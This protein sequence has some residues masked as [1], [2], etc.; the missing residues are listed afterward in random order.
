MDTESRKRRA[1]ESALGFVEI[2]MVVG[3]GTGSTA[4]HF[5]EALA[6]IRHRIDGAVASSEATAAR[7]RAHGMRVLDLNAVD[8]VSVY[9]DGADECTRHRQLVK[10]GGGA[11]TREKIVAAVA[12]RFV[13]IVDD[14]KLVD[15]LGAAFPVAVEVIPMARGHVARQL[16]ALGG[17]PF[18]REGFVTDNGNAILDVR[19]LGTPR[20]GRDRERDQ[21]DRGGRGERSLCPAPGR[22]SADR[23]ARIG[24]QAAMKRPS[25]R[26]RYHRGPTPDETPGGAVVKGRGALSNRSGRYESTTRDIADDG[27]GSLDDTLEALGR[28]ETS[29]EPDTSRTVI[30]RNQSPDIPF[31]RSIN[32]YRGCEHGCI[33]CYARP[34]HAWLGL[35]P[36]RDFETKL[37]YKA[38]AVELL[39]D[40]LRAP[41]YRCAPIALG[42]NTDPYQPVERR[43]RITRG[44][45]AL[46]R[47]CAH[48]ATIVTKSTL[49][50]RD[51]DLLV[52]MAERSL[53]GVSVSVT[54]LDPDLARRMEPRAAGPRQRLAAIER[55]RRLDVPVAVL[56]APII[57]GLN[58][59]E[60]E[61]ILRSVR[62]RGSARRGLR[63]AAAAAGGRRPVPRMARRPLPAQGEPGPGP[64]PR[65]PRRAGLSRRV[66]NP[67]ARHRTLRRPHRPSVPA[68]AAPARLPRNAGPRFEPIRA[69]S[70]GRR[71]AG[72]HGRAGTGPPARPAA[73]RARRVSVIANP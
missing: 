1:A 44:I 59:H 16:V 9:V 50:E 35:S 45:L 30:A 37:F 70:G 26:A 67:H 52:P 38:N 23:R 34:T 71:P 46:L 61:A 57:P 22:R 13:C 48:P 39:R 14:S 58:D 53:V 4:N 65:D 7:L 36:G 32:P 62:G 41:G 10:G 56:V 18:W 20:P 24:S 64:R 68:I 17:N 51:A 11:L 29:L 19:G 2:G 31:D 33:Y 5:I 8:E 28:A 27:W 25:A 66:R 73:L 49:V 6:G 40:E 72:G 60:I 42:T 63:A 15:V 21:P 54:T 43:L 55:L 69:A 3:V 47:E 12:R